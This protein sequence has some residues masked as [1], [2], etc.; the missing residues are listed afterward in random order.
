MQDH[1]NDESSPLHWQTKELTECLRKDSTDITKVLRLLD[2]GVPVGSIVINKESF[3]TLAAFWGHDEVAKELITRGAPLNHQNIHGETA[4]TQALSRN[5]RAITDMLVDAGANVLVHLPYKS[6]SFAL[7][8]AEEKGWTD[9]AKKIEVLMKKQ[10]P[11]L[12]A[13]TTTLRRGI[14]PVRTRRFKAP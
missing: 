6:K 4:L 12:I 9:I 7:H 8:A 10:L 5:R 11:T 13:D 3:L 1:F 2:A 14:T